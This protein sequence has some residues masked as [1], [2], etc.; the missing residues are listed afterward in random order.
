MKEPT[1][2]NKGDIDKS[3]NEM[4]IKKEESRLA[5]HDT[6]AQVSSTYRN[7]KCNAGTLSHDAADQGDEEAPHGNITINEESYAVV[8]NQY[9]GEHQSPLQEA[10]AHTNRETLHDENV[11]GEADDGEHY[12]DFD[13][14]SDIWETP[15]ELQHG[16]P[17]ALSVTPSIPTQQEE[18]DEADERDTDESTL[19]LSAQP[20]IIVDGEEHSVDLSSVGM[21]STTHQWDEQLIFS[22]LPPHLKNG[23]RHYSWNPSSTRGR[24]RRWDSQHVF[25]MRSIAR[26]TAPT[27]CHED[28]IEVEAPPRHKQEESSSSSSIG[29]MVKSSSQSA[30]DELNVSTS[31]HRHHEDGAKRGEEEEGVPLSFASPYTLLGAPDSKYEQY[32]CVVDSSQ[33]DRAVEIQLGSMAR[34]HMRG[35]HLAWMAFFVAF[36]T[37]FALTPLLSEIAISL[38]LTK[39]Q[40]WTSSIFGVA[41]SA[42]TRILIG[43]VCDKY[44]ARWAMGGTLFLSAIPMALTALVQTSVGLSVLRLFIGLAGSAFV[45]SQYWTSTM[46]TPEVAGTANALAAGWGNLGGGVTQLVMGSLLFPL[47]KIV[48]GGEGWSRAQRTHEDQ[49]YATSSDLAWRT[50]CV[51]PALMCLIM[52]Y[53]VIFKADD[54]PKGNYIKRNREGFMPPV[55]ATKSVIVG[56]HDFNTW[57][58][59]IQYGCCF[60][61]EITMINAAALYFKEE[62]GLS[63]EVSAAVA[64]IFG[65]MNLFARG[66][67]GFLSDIMNSKRGM[68]GRLWLQTLSLLTEGALVILFSKT[69]TLGGAIAVMIASSIFVQ[70]AEGSTYGIVPYV[71]PSVTGSISGI[72][73]AGGNVGGVGFASIFRR[74]DYRDAFSAMGWTAMI[75]AVL[76][77]PIAIQGHA[78]LLCGSDAE[79]VVDRRTT[80]FEE[81]GGNIPPI[82]YKIKAD[83][84]DLPYMI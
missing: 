77:I 14:E 52:T 81:L 45:T 21:G 57:I 42:V 60:G 47:L 53:F 75:S 55:S 61:V 33:E 4:E 51:V 30:I 56:M 32:R 29:P 6:P 44:G 65:W 84:G 79:E 64:S 59:F 48:Y 58:L 49:D 36:F 76:T 54:C 83:T 72:V 74:I 5:P 25:A 7:S 38:N 43:P 16:A 3:V 68:R 10:L 41:G 9:D 18:Q 1:D 2:D 35:F 12:D 8:E 26:R 46:F 24:S 34:P 23:R 73:G 37:W 20:E 27:V 70:A 19:S 62:F 15:G 39:E 82:A 31:N 28:T 17:I 40:I 80:H 13:A 22:T 11:I 78:S 50:S 67:G 71:N 63:T 69:L 66:L